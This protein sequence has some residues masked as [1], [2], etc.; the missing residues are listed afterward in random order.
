LEN[1]S[2]PR[3][4][5]PLVLDCPDEFQWS[6]GDNRATCPRRVDSYKLSGGPT[7]VHTKLLID[8]IMRQTTVLI[9]QLSAAAGIRAPLAHLADEVFLSLSKELE[10]QGVPKKIV[11]DMFGLALRTYQ[12]RVQRLESSATDSGVT[13]WQVVND[14]LQESGQLTR[15]QI[16]ERFRHD[17][18]EALGAVLSDLVQSGFASRTGRATSAV[19][20]ATP[21]E[22]RRLLARQDKE[23]TAV[24]LVWL[25]ICQ[26]PGT[27]AEDVAQRLGLEEDL[28]E[29]IVKRLEREGQLTSSALGPLSAKQFVIDVGSEIGWEAAVFDH[30]QAVAAAITAKL[31][32]GQARSDAADTIGGRTVS[33]EVCTGHPQEKEVLQLLAQMRKATDELWERVSA[34]NEQSPIDEDQMK[35]VVFYFGQYVTGEAE[36]E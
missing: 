25:D 35:R 2:E 24:A 5:A 14:Y 34:T 36:D 29:A 30:F 16:F 20:V 19:F 3:A 1:S 27:L 15:Q 32:R 23:D 28:T 6:S 4:V 18:P 33:F 31:R 9:A 21:P 10:E 26:H 7:R 11:A 12:R 8:S 13:L 22:A 17:D